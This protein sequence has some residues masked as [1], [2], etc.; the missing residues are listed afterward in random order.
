MS[1]GKRAGGFDIRNFIGAAVGIIGV[2]LLLV[3]LAWDPQLD[4][5]GGVHANLWTGVA[6]VVVAALFFLWAR[7]R[8]LA[9]A[10]E[11]DDARR[12]RDAR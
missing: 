3:A 8:P 10:P 2:Y 4:K 1:A 9:P 5:T 11:P 12:E 6:M 7:L